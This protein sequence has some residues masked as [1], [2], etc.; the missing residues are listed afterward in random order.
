[1]EQFQSEIF[2]VLYSFYNWNELSVN[3]IWFDTNNLTHS[4][5]LLP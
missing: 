1:M 4:N 5:K 2:N 3:S